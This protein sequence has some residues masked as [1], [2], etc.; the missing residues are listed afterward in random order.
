MR[1]IL[2][3]LGICLEPC[4]I[5]CV[6]TSTDEFVCNVI[7]HTQGEHTVRKEISGPR[8]E[9]VTGSCK[10]FHIENLNEFYSSPDACFRVVK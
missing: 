8:K 4:L 10:I 2:S 5:F 6:C 1:I 3:G 7:S 9:K